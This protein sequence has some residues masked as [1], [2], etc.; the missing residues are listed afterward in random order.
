MTEK[1][2]R[3]KPEARRDEILS[4]ALGLAIKT[5]YSMLTRDAVAEAAGIS[6]P[7]V[8]Y[9]FKSM[10]RLRKAIMRAAV[11]RELLSVVLQGLMLDDPIAMGAS[12][13]LQ[14]RARASVA[15]VDNKES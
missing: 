8:L 13:D 6:G 9:H 10:A 12:T 4:A 15:L 11:A 1:Q 7:A 2:V 14:E 5:H 3:L